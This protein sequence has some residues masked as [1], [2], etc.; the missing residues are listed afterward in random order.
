MI[1][2]DMPENRNLQQEYT[3]GFF[4]A[5][6]YDEEGMVTD[7]NNLPT[8]VVQSE[9]NL[10]EHM[11]LGLVGLKY[12]SGVVTVLGIL[13]PV[14]ISS[15][16]TYGA[17]VIG[18]YRREGIVYDDGFCSYGKILAIDDE[19]KFTLPPGYVDHDHP[20]KVYKCLLL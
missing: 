6:S 10:Q 19:C 16:S 14:W 9:G 8:K 17:K 1:D 11:H 13:Q 18:K 2:S 4:D 12:T 7:F 15:R 20:K 3:R 5:A